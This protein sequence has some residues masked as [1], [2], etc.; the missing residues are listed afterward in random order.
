MP[1]L[2]GWYLI[3]EIFRRNTFPLLLE[4]TSLSQSWRNTTV[5]CITSTVVKAFHAFF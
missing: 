2:I 4:D 5:F 3:S 1:V